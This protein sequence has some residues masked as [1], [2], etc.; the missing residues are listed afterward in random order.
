[1]PHS[2]V[3]SGKHDDDAAL[4]ERSLLHALGDIAVDD[5]TLREADR[6]TQAW[7]KDPDSIPSDVASID[8]LLACRRAGADRIDALRAVLTQ[9][10]NPENIQIALRALGAF[11]DPTTLQKAL[12]VTLTDDVKSQDIHKVLGSTLGHRATRK[13]S[14]DWVTTHWDALKKKLPATL[15][16]Y[17]VGKLASQNCSAEE[18]TAVSRFLEPRVKEVEG[19]ERPLAEGLE[20][21]SLCEALHD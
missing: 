6:V 15:V 3:F 11:S 12:D 8:V 7:L 17:V 13:A 9:A 16:G 18:R 1:L 4:L 14:F 21:A 2:K 10:K 19:A 20:A 5:A